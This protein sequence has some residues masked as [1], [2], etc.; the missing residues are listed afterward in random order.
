MRN[1]I[2]AIFAISLFAAT[3]VMAQNTGS[4]SAAKPSTPSASSRAAGSAPV[5][6]RQPTAADVGSE[7]SA[8]DLSA[9]DKAL[10]R[11]IKGICRGC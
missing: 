2:A 4:S 8:T 10:D 3:T 6:H 11:K 5:G 1:L 9:E 7:K